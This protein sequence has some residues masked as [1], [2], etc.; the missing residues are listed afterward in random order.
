MTTTDGRSQLRRGGRE[1]VMPTQALL[2][3]FR[4]EL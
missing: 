4:I 1:L 3:R 2:L